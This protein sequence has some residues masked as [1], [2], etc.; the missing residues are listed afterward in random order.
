PRCSSGDGPCSSANA[1]KFVIGVPY[2][3]K[4]DRQAVQFGSV[5]WSRCWIC[6]FSPM[7]TT[8]THR[9]TKRTGITSSR[10]ACEI[11]CDPEIGKHYLNIRR[12]QPR[13]CQHKVAVHIVA[14]WALKPNATLIGP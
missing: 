14:F 5:P 10:S 9:P 1:A 6:Q 13:K 7:A 2:V 8:A 3:C 4:A 12:A 11:P